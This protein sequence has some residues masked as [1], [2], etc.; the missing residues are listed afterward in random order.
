MSEQQC[1]DDNCKY[2]IRARNAIIQSFEPAKQ[3]YNSQ[4][5]DY[6][7]R[8]Y[9]F[10]VLDDAATSLNQI[11]IPATISSKAAF[12]EIVNKMI[13]IWVGAVENNARNAYR[14][15]IGGEF[16]GNVRNQFKLW[17]YESGYIYTGASTGDLSTMRKYAQSQINQFKVLYEN[18]SLATKAQLGQLR[19]LLND[20]NAQTVI[21]QSLEKV[22]EDITDYETKIVKVRNERDA[23]N[24]QFI[25]ERK[26]PSK[27]K[28]PK[29]KVLQDYILAAFIISYV[30]AAFVGIA[31]FTTK[32]ESWISGLLLSSG[33]SIVFG[34]I[35]YS[36]ILYLA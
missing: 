10:K 21:S 28:K 5:Y 18:V 2:L 30:V 8:V 17:F 34:A 6:N 32:A 35:I 26:V 1:Q 15:N 24:Q 20:T 4:I 36:L 31:Y 25:D 33:M 9:A 3:G 22:E 7:L 27:I 13:D 14:F 12:D 23:L 11:Q 19:V 29:V 16:V